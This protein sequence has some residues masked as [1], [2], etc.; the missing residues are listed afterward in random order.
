MS[1]PMNDPQESTF[2]SNGQPQGAAPT[3]NKKAAFD[4][5]AAFDFSDAKL[6]SAQE[7]DQILLVGFA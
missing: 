3:E 6:Q 2:R 7:V 4:K 5:N 1:S